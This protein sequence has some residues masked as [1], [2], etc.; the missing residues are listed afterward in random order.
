MIGS[1]N[2]VIKTGGGAPLELSTTGIDFIDYD[3]TVLAHYDSVPTTL[4]TAP[5]IEG[6]DFQEWNWTIADLQEYFTAIPD[7][8]V[9]VGATRKP[10]DG[11]THIF[12]SLSA[13]RLSPLLHLFR[14]NTN[15]TVTVDWGD[16]TVETWSGATAIDMPHTYAQAGDYEI[17]ISAESGHIY[18]D[19]GSPQG[20]QILLDPNYQSS[21]SYSHAY[22]AYITEIWFGSN[23]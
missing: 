4:P 21:D 12:V 5:T 18:A 8:Y 19:N 20:T 6:L 9:C 10:S 14:E 23:I 17:K 1:S 7:G 16:N 13:G 22:N 3:G 15:T 2:A 11:K